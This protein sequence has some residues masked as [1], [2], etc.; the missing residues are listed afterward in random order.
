MAQ[1]RKGKGIAV[2]LSLVAIAG[3]IGYIIYRSNK[4]KNKGNTSDAGSGGS[5]DLGTTS[6]S[7]S[8][9]SAPSSSSSSTSSGNPFATKDDLLKFQRWVIKVIGDTKI[10]GKG[11]STGKGDDGIWGS[12]SAS[13]YAKYQSKYDASKVNN[14]GTMM[15]TPIPSWLIPQPS[16]TAS[17][18]PWLNPSSGGG[19]PTNSGGQFGIT[20]GNVKI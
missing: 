12:K 9:S 20:Y 8:S 17:L 6:T 15:S 5:F 1:Q 2:V 7:S 4:N 13:A 18:L 10:L 14:D 16:P 11:G 3:V 19:S